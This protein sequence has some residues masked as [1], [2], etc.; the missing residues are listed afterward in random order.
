MTGIEYMNNVCPTTSKGKDPNKEDVADA[1]EDGIAEG[2]KQCKQQLM[3]DA[4]DAEILEMPDNGNTF[5]EYTHLEIHV[6]NF[7]KGKYGNGDKVKLI[8]IKEE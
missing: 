3:N 5:F 2:F 4:I 7:S 1:F 8:I 6:E